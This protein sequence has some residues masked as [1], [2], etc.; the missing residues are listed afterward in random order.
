MGDVT[1]LP[2]CNFKSLGNFVK[3]INLNVTLIKT[4]K[5]YE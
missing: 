5:S 1:E 4:V 2:S 3:L